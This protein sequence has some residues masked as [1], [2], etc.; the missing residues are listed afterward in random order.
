VRNNA[1]GGLWPQDISSLSHLAYFN[2]GGNQLSGA[3]PSTQAPPSLIACVVLPNDFHALPNQ[4]AMND[5][6]SLASRC[7]RHTTPGSATSSGKNI[8]QDRTRPAK[9]DGGTS[10]RRADMAPVQLA[11][12][13]TESLPPPIVPEASEIPLPSGVQNTPIPPGAPVPT[14]APPHSAD[15]SS[16]PISAAPAPPMASLYANGHLDGSGSRSD[17]RENAS[18]S[19]QASRAAYALM[20][21]CGVM[22]FL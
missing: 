6:R 5:I 7:L 12:P 19:A 20:I 22:Q 10:H 18:F 4:D 3:F 15:S 2:V 13:T 14:P 17:I 8:G 21:V 1:I 11:P 9:S 16:M